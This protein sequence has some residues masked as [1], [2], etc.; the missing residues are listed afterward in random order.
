MVLMRIILLKLL[1]SEDFL[2]SQM[3]SLETIIELF[4]MSQ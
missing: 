1:G 2:L 4:S 3:L